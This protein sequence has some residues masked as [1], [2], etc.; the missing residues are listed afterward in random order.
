M[1][2]EIADRMNPAPTNVVVDIYQNDDITYHVITIVKSAK[3]VLLFGMIIGR[4]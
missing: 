3:P 2:W 4:G 1:V